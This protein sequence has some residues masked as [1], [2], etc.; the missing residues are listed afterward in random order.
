VTKPAWM[1]P[2]KVVVT[3]TH[4]ACAAGQLVMDVN[5]TIGVDGGARYFVAST[6]A[7][8]PHERRARRPIVST[9]CRSFVSARGW[10]SAA[11]ASTTTASLPERDAELLRAIDEIHADRPVLGSRRIVDELMDEGLIVDRKAVQRLMRLAAGIE[12]TYERPRTRRAGA[13]AG[14]C[15]LHQPRP[16]HPPTPT[17]TR[18]TSP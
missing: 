2:A 15:S 6:Q 18:F 7:L 13:G 9:R 11:R 17:A 3:E 8:T 10:A 5:A 12:A 1:Y 14:L 16:D 4:P